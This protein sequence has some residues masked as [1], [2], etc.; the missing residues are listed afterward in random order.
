MALFRALESAR[1]PGARLFDDPFASGF[2]RPS[3]WMVSQL[4][5]LP[6]VNALVAS[7]IDHRW[8][9]ARPSGIARTRLIDD[10]VLRAVEG[11]VEQIVVLG[12]GFDCR[13]YRLGPLQATRVFEVDRAEVLAMKRERLQLALG[14]WPEHVRFVDIDLGRQDPGEALGAARFDRARRTFFLW[15]GVTNYLDA[16]AVD[17]TLRFIA[18]VVAGSQVCFTYVDRAALDG[19]MTFPGQRTLERTLGRA[20][21]RWTFGFDPA[22]LGGY[23]AARGLRLLA[24]VGSLEYRAQYMGPRGRHM[25]GYEFYRLAVAC[26]DTGVTTP[27]PPARAH[28]GRMVTSPCR[29]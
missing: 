29:R 26:I 15:E 5:R 2:L 14:A 6:C 22:D 21:E 20:G 23:L 1:R 17:A 27:A 13:A 4:A 12:A 19:S 9:G 24:D 16:E 8:P 28:T 25:L 7:V 18:T 3:L 10:M 11:G